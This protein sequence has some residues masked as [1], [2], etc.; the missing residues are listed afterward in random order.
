MAGFVCVCM[1][2]RNEMY[3]VIHWGKSVSTHAQDS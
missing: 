3:F 2:R 1:E